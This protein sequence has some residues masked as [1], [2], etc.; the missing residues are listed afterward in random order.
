MRDHDGNPADGPNNGPAAESTK[1]GSPDGATNGVAFARIPFVRT[2]STA[3]DVLGVS[4]AA[5]TRPEGPTPPRGRHRECAALDHLVTDLWAGEPGAF[6][7]RGSHG[8]GKSALIEYLV[9]RATGCL[10]LRVDPVPSEQD[11]D[12]AALQQVCA[13]VFPHART[14]PK[15][16][17]EALDHVFG[18]S[19]GPPPSAVL[20]GMAV[21]ALF[22]LEAASHPVICV[23]DDAQLLDMAS[24]QALGFTARRLPDQPVAVVLATAHDPANR[25]ADQPADHFSG[26]PA[27][28]LAAQWAGLRELRLG[29]LPE[30][31]A[32]ALLRDGLIGPLDGPVRD[33]MAA[34]AHGNPRVVELAA[35][36]S[37][38]QLAGGYGLPA[39][40]GSDL[41]AVHLRRLV[42]LPLS[43]RRLLLL[44][45]ADPTGDAI[46]LWSA[47]HR[48]G[49]NPEDAQPAIAASIIELDAPVRFCHPHLRSVVYRRASAHERRITHRALA[50]ATDHRADPARA[51]WHMAHATSGSDED[52]ASALEHTAESARARGG[53][54][55]EGAFHARAVDLTADPALRA[56][57]ALRAAEAKWRSGATAE[58]RRLLAIAQAGPLGDASTARAGF[59]K[60]HLVPP[61]EG[62]AARAGLLVDVAARNRSEQPHL[63]WRAF[64]AALEASFHAGRLSDSSAMETALAVRAAARDPRSS[65]TADLSR[66]D[67]VTANLVIAA[68]DMISEGTGVGA[69]AVASLVAEI[70]GSD[71]IPDLDSMPL[72]VRLARAVWDDHAWTHLA[73]RGVDRARTGGALGAL[74][75]ALNSLA[76]ISVQTA[77]VDAATRPANEAATIAAALRIPFGP[78]GRLAAVAWSGQADETTQLI[79]EVTPDAISNGEG[80]WLTATEWAVALLNNGAGRYADAIESAERGSAHADELGFSLSSMVELVEAAARLGAPHRADGIVERLSSYADAFNTDWING[81]A[82]R[83][84]ALLSNGPDA[85]GLYRLAVEQLERT[86][87]RADLARTH[88]LYGEWLR[89]E[90]RR[91]GAREHLLAA[92]EMFVDFGYS[93]FVERTRRELVGTGTTPRRRSGL[94]IEVLTPQEAQIARMAKG[95]RTNSEI[96]GEL[97]I[98]PRTVEWHLR[99]VYMKLGIETRRDLGSVLP[100]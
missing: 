17:R 81:V 10:V 97:F 7:I 2:A 76:V 50:A 98:S 41:E 61:L 37:P 32:R 79:S 82:A 52:A 89:R 34:E 99:N 74:P 5:A 66:A 18:V 12:F 33:R 31:D 93:A 27:E 24:A 84:R 88:L 39:R 48:L 91:S 35:H 43:T 62:G 42:Q 14:L 36:A 64:C 73:A 11:L 38:E 13:P 71:D 96:A 22:A 25:L 1:N 19:D 94:A 56:A 9:E 80:E 28:Q 75:A 20:V 58:A 8:A 78:Y 63:G 87:M 69:P 30:A 51:A 21:R 16:Q 90:G 54:P 77:G 95:G 67:F 44:A 83:C 68:A 4:P 70:C 49:L 86:S 55:A 6:V 15:A 46:L 26:G 40:I 59:L 92:H 47:A 72:A 60:A 3:D 85:D 57:R 65:G 45:A 29:G 100:T 53:I 23:V